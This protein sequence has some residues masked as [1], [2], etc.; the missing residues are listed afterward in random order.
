MNK[1]LHQELAQTTKVQALR[2][3]NGYKIQA[4]LPCGKVIEIR[5]GGKSLPL[6]ANFFDGPANQR[7]V[8]AGL[9]FTFSKAPV[10]IWGDK[11][12]KSFSV[13]VI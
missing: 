7:G 2:T 12:L 1:D 5:K 10:S 8:G 11:C 6:K 3:S 13:E 9:Y 4:V